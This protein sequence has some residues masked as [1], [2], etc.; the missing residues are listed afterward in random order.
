MNKQYKQDE[1]TTHYKDKH[2]ETVE[3]RSLQSEIVDRD[4]KDIIHQNGKIN[5]TNSIR[6]PD[7]KYF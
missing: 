4:Q 5:E 1:M 2:D 6:L 3:A 7:A